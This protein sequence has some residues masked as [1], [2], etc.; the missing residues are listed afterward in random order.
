MTYRRFTTT[1]AWI[2]K[3]FKEKQPPGYKIRKA[4]KAIE[5]VF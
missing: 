5:D 3:K 1:V 4:L 2:W